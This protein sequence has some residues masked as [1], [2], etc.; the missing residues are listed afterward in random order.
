[1]AANLLG[2][3]AVTFPMGTVEGLPVGGQIMT[4]P[5]ADALAVGVT[6]ALEVDNV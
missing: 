3:P 1:M 5:C 6:H 2:A 4:A